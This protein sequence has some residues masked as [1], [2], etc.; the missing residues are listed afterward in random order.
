LIFDAAGSLYGTTQSG[1]GTGCGGGGCGVVWKLTRYVN[2][3]WTAT[4]LH[5]FTGADGANPAGG[6]I[7]DAA[8]NLYGTTQAGGAYG[9]G[10]VFKLQVNVNGTWTERVLYSFTGGA[11]GANPAAG[12]IFDPVG[13][14]YGTTLFGGSYGGGV[15][16]KVDMAG[17]EEVLH[18]FTE[19]AFWPYAGLVRDQAGNFYGT[20]SYGGGSGPCDNNLGC[21]TVFKLEPTGNETVLHGFSD[22]PDGRYLLAGLIQDAEGN[23][24]GTSEGGG[25]GSCYAD[26]GCG[27]VFKIDTSGTETVLYR[28]TGGSDGAQPTTALV[29]DAAGNLYGTT[30]RGGV[31]C[32]AYGCGTVFKLDPTGQE[33]VLHKFQGI[34]QSPNSPLII[35]AAGNLYGTTSGG[36]KNYGIVFKI[37]P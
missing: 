17:N 4:I 29:R 25:M 1:G 28:F 27:T 15:L 24:Y 11:D 6:V 37:T 13:N 9:A 18:T 16:F 36:T 34:G 14:L 7:F 2:G 30:S 23:L 33:T 8:G 20:T 26:I 32:P 31:N 12:V 19:D 21:G 10:V 35:D 22:E 5:V 3:K